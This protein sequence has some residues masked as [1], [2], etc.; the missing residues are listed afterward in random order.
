[1]RKKSRSKLAR[2]GRR[3]D[4]APGA[5]ETASGT[6]QGHRSRAS[7]LAPGERCQPTAGDDSG[8]RLHHSDGHRRHGDRSLALYLRPAVRGLAW[9]RAAT[10]LKRRQGTS[11]LHLEDGRSI[12]PNAS[13]RWRDVGHPLCPQQERR[14][15]PVGQCAAG[16]PS[17]TPRFGC[18]RQQDGADY[19]GGS[20][21]G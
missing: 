9:S 13:C 21:P 8:R 15:R 16:A 11:R 12:Y 20:R 17:S 2:V 14:R 1:M 6:D 18:P 19:L 4:A 5:V 7:C 10:E 3:K